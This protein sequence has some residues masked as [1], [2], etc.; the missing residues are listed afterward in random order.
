MSPI[1]FFIFV[2]SCKEVNEETYLDS[3]IYSSFVGEKKRSQNRQDREEEK[4]FNELFVTKVE[5][6]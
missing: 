2:F 1:V 3:L 4:L 5:L 6:C